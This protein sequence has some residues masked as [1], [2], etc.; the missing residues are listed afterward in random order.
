VGS[1]E[2][3][4]VIQEHSWSIEHEGRIVGCGGKVPGSEP[5]VWAWWVMTRREALTHPF[6]LTRLLRRH[7]DKECAV[8]THFAHAL[9]LTA[10]RWLLALGFQPTDE[11]EH[12]AALFV[13]HG[14]M[15][16]CA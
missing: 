15:R 1:E 14:A 4:Q 5:D 2:A 8:G 3:M 7:L 9:D 13:R 16:E 6:E 10:E 11:E 12:G